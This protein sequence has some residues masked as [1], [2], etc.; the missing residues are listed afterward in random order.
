MSRKKVR[1]PLWQ[2]PADPLVL[3]MEIILEKILDSKRED[4]DVQELVPDIDF[5]LNCVGNVVEY[6]SVCLEGKKTMDP[7]LKRIDLDERVGLK[8]GFSKGVLR[9]TTRSVTDNTQT[10]EEVKKWR[11]RLRKRN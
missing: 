9:A 1:K 6:R 11:K 3:K 2:K 5:F 8:L 4:K 10:L 7:I